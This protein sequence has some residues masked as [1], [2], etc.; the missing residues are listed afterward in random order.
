MQDLFK[1]FGMPEYDPDAEEAEGE[2]KFKYKFK[3][4]EPK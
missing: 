3:Q 1:G 2:S 4:N